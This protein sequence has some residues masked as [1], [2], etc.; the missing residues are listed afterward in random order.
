MFARKL[1]GTLPA[2]SLQVQFVS[3]IRSL[4]GRNMYALL[5]SLR[6]YALCSDAPSGRGLLS[7]DELVHR[8]LVLLGAP[9]TIW[10]IYKASI[11]KRYLSFIIMASIGLGLLVIAAF[12]ELVSEFE[13]PLTV[14][15][16]SILGFSHLW[17]WLRARRLDSRAQIS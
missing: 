14:L 5:D 3:W 15:G 13:A 7:G 2:A 10:L 17:R 12:V 6:W 9:A 8:L 16:A 11:T 1:S 4:R